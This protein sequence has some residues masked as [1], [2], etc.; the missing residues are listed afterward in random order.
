MRRSAVVW[1]FAFLGI[2]VLAAGWGTFQ[3]VKASAPL[4]FMDA[5]GDWGFIDRSGKVIIPAKFS[6][7]RPFR[8]GAA[9]VGGTTPRYIDETGAVIWSIPEEGW[10]KAIADIGLADF[11][12]ES[13]L[14]WS[15]MGDFREGL[16]CVKVYAGPLQWRFGFIDKTGEYAVKPQFSGAGDFSEGLAP[17][18]SPQSGSYGYIRKDGTLAVQPRYENAAPFRD[19][20]AAVSDKGKYG[21]IDKSGK[22]V[23][24]FPFDQ[25]GGF[26]EGLARFGVRAP[27]QKA[28]GLYGGSLDNLVFS[29]K[30]GYINKSG[31]VAV[32]AQFDEAGDFAEGLAAVKKGALWGY[33]DP[34]GKLVIAP[35]FDE[36]D[37]FSE[38]LAAVNKGGRWGYID[39]MGRPAIGCQFDDAFSFSG[40]L[41]EVWLGE[42]MGYILPTGKFFWG[43][44]K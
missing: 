12:L 9:L 24:D 7:A 16:A 39:K 29:G 1:C 26:C 14:V 35:Q 31:N 3:A 27:G 18:R 43:P 8:E 33:I 5:S 11:E 2:A 21:F 32:A 25:V 44:A 41:A 30:W 15:Q 42:K 20:L 17:V 22:V 10:E 23:I 34:Q 6:K 28:T 38:G 13:D 40:G 19:G 36:A 4:R 37:A